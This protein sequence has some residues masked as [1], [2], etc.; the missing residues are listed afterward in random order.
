MNNFP[1][2]NHKKT[3]NQ[4][5]RRVVRVDR[6]WKQLAA[7]VDRST[8]KRLESLLVVPEGSSQSTLHFFLTPPPRHPP[9]LPDHPGR[10]YG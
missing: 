10:T 8:A 4:T 2:Q 3:K 9:P 1:N 6:L 5:F 7:R